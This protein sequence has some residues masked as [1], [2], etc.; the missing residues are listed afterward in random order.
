MAVTVEK[1]ESVRLS[2]KVNEHSKSNYKLNVALSEKNRKPEGMTVA[3]SI[4]LSGNAQTTKI[5]VSGSARLTG[6]EDDI[7]AAIGPGKDKAP[8]KVVEAIYEKI[9]GLVYLLAG[10]MRVP[11]PAPNLVRKSS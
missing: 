3:F 7:Q 10:S 5:T 1:I 4:E 6:S 11:Y 9:Y 8:P 2:D